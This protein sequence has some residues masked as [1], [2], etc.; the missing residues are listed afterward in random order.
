MIESQNKEIRK[1]LES[2]HKITSL[3]ALYKFGCFRLG[4]RIYDLRKQGLHII[5]KT[6][7]V[8]SPSV[9]NG[10][11]HFTEYNL[12]NDGKAKNRK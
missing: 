4:A 6:V 9:Y 11:K 12:Q 5:S 8:I 1:Y 7:E 2:G 3:D 10:R